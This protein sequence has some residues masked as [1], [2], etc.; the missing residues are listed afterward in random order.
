MTN[1]PK[2]REN[3]FKGRQRVL[4]LF[5]SLVLLGVAGC[6]DDA[7][8]RLANR[9]V[10]C[11]PGGPGSY[12]SVGMQPDDL[13]GLCRRGRD[14]P[15]TQAELRC[16]ERFPEGDCGPFRMCMDEMMY[17]HLPPNMRGDLPPRLRGEAPSGGEDRKV[18]PK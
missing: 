1:R 18:A 16:A 4:F 5:A 2:T 7:C 15:T 8:D 11:D 6:R 13:P 10:E 12:V 17:L 3:S 9:Q 14:R